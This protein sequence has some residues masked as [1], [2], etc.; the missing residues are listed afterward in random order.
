MAAHLRITASSRALC[1]R[2][3]RE[4]AHAST[5]LQMHRLVHFMK[6]ICSA[7]ACACMISATAPNADAPV[8][9]RGTQWRRLADGRTAIMV[10][11]TV[12]KEWHM[13]WMNPGDSGA[14]PKATANLPAGWK[15][16]RPIWPRPRI[17]KQQ[18]E[19]L[20]VHEGAWSWLVPIEGAT[21]DQAPNFAIELRLSWMACKQVCVV[22]KATVTVAPPVGDIEPLAKIVEGSAIPTEVVSEYAIKLESTQPAHFT[23]AGPAH[24]ASAAR[25]LQAVDAGVSLQCKNPCVATVQDDRIAIDAPVQLRAQ[26]ALGQPFAIS[27][28]LLLG[29]KPSDPCLWIRSVVISSA[30]QPR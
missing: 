22:G 7:I 29:D 5:I 24:G 25:F 26:D 19:T 16:G 3:R 8:Q 4:S 14:P 13:Y 30:T 9:V 28:L 18:D 2:A 10:Q 23:L 17:L 12:E 21:L 1:T 11:F 20:F 6:H 15:L 27:G